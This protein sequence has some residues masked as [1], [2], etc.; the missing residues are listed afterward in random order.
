MFTV[1]V[2]LRAFVDS[3]SATS[4]DILRD[5]RRVPAPGVPVRPVIPHQGH[6][7]HR[8]QLGHASLC[9]ST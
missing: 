2:D 9:T 7:H 1:P 4:W 8:H 6:R 5:V 3:Q